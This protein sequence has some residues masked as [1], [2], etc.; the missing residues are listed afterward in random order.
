MD[1]FGFHLDRAF[2][3]AWGP[4]SLGV[5]GRQPG[6]PELVRLIAIATE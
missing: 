4:D 2:L 6:D 1:E 3:H 5:D